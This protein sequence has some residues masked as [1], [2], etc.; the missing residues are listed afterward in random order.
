MIPPAPSK[1]RRALRI[2][3]TIAVAGGII[4]ALA[5]VLLWSAEVQVRT[6]AV[7]IQAA[8][9]GQP[10]IVVEADE[11]LFTLMAALNA[12]G[13][14]DENNEKGMYPVRRQVRTQLAARN[15]PSLIRLRLYFQAHPSQYVAWV[16]ERGAPPRFS[17]AESEWSIDGVPAFA[18]FG[19]DGALADFY[20]EADIASLWKQ[21]EPEYARE[22]ARYQP[23][24]NGAVKEALDYA[25][26]D[27]RETPQIVILPNLLDSYWRGYGP[28]VGNV[29]Y[30][31]IGPSDTPNTVLVQHEMLHA[32]VN[33]L[34]SANLGVINPSQAD[35]LYQALRTR[36]APGYGSWE[37]LLDESVIR[38]IGARL[39]A[40]AERPSY[41]ATQEAQ[42]F[43]LVGPLATRLEAYEASGQRL[44]EF[45][46][47]LLGSLNDINP[48]GISNP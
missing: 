4:A 44:P 41:L 40:P 31:V 39:L 30:V 3:V 45:V 35:A 11:R 43:M 47:A 10:H 7:T 29:S 36:V 13:Y 20:R 34:V 16:L 38:A 14:N 1:P 8:T 33:P 22:V 28:V 37:T 9:A 25:R 46:P 27:E 12:A 2:L 42:G 32:V 15:I 48:Q 17:R 6:E 21:Y 26:L 24:A 18:F 5:G 23:L 19:L